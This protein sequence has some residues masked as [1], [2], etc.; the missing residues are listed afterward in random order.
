MQNA[1]GAR[2]EHNLV[3]GF[4]TRSGGYNAGIRAWNSD[5]V[6][7]RFNEVTGGHGTRDSMAHDLYGGNN[8]TS[9]STTTATTTRAASC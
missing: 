5:A 4:N 6:R 9:T 8:G 3:D 2:V 1:V 7:Y